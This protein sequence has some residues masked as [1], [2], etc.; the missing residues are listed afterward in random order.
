M[1]LAPTEVEH[2]ALLA[3]LGI[4]SSEVERFSEQLGAVL[5]HMD[6]LGE[7]RQV[8]ILPTSSATTL[9]TVMR[10]DEARPSL[11]ISEVLANAPQSE[12]GYFRVPVV[13]EHGAEGATGSED[14]S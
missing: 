7:L 6:T 2:V 1:K 10:R 14:A 12:D 9:K 4:T 11:P 13:L 5:Q 8:E 3:R